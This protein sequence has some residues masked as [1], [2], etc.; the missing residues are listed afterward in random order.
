M[1]AGKLVERGLLA[2]IVLNPMYDGMFYPILYLLA[3]Y[4]RS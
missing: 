1:P 2:L 4:T 3:T